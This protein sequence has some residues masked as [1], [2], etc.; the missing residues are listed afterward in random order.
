M[1]GLNEIIRMNNA[2]ADAADRLETN[3]NRH[4]SFSGDAL[5]GVIIH[6]AKLRNTAFLP[7]I[8]AKRFLA[9]WWSV[10]SQEARNRLVESYF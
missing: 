2:A 5:R 7:P 4:C 9:K 10:N 3:F 8:K 6:S 1:H